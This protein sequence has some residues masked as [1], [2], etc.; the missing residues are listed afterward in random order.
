MMYKEEIAVRLRNRIADGEL[1]SRK[2]TGMDYAEINRRIA[3]GELLVTSCESVLARTEEARDEFEGWVSERRVMDTNMVRVHK[4]LLTLYAIN[5][6]CADGKML[7]F[8]DFGR[9]CP[10]FID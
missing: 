7:R 6:E 1:V 4:G 8:P 9:M 5:K 10:L 3:R 2:G